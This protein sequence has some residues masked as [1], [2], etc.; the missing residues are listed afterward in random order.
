MSKSTTSRRVFRFIL[1]LVILV[2][3]VA[4]FLW[5]NMGRMVKSGAESAISFILDVPVTIGSVSI[6]PI[7]QRVVVDQFKITNPDGFNTDEAFSTERID[8]TVDLMSFTTDHPVIE[9]ILIRSPQVTLE[10]G[11]RGS[12]LTQLIE[13]ASRFS[14]EDDLAEETAPEEAGMT[15]EVRTITIEEGSTAFS[16][17]ILQGRQMNI[18]L[19]RIEF[20]DVTSASDP[21]SI[22]K[23]LS[24]VLLAV[25]TSTG[26]AA[27][28]LVPDE[29]ARDLIQSLDRTV[30]KLKGPFKDIK[31][32]EFLKGGLE[33]LKASGQALQ[34]MAVKSEEM[35]KGAG[36]NSADAVQGIVDKGSD[37]LKAGMEKIE[38]GGEKLKEGVGGV[39]N[40]FDRK[41]E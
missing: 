34:N 24:K 21:L 31:D 35:I 27:Q 18:P 3:V 19:P 6:H 15:L 32:M 8:V 1:I 12:N 14:S 5:I 37:T 11:L 9:N 7:Q 2:I 41:K 4:L 26:K 13:N 38:T 39:L 36:Q 30:E 40:L 28:G 20:T 29:L 25:L 10:Q 23:I 16:A 17:P 22:A 33:Q